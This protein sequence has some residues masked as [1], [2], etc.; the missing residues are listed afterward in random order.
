MCSASSSAALRYFLFLDSLKLKVPPRPRPHAQTHRNELFLSVSFFRPHKQIEL[1]GN[2]MRTF[3]EAVC[4]E[5][6]RRS[7][8]CCT[9]ITLFTPGVHGPLCF[10]T[11]QTETFR[12]DVTQ[13]ENCRVELLEVMMQTDMFTSCLGQSLW[14]P[15]L[16]SFQTETFLVSLDARLPLLSSLQWCNQHTASCLPLRTHAVWL[17]TMMRRVFSCVSLNGYYFLNNAAPPTWME[18]LV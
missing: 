15:T 17:W 16:S 4:S 7:L 10:R 5:S 8:L 14:C 1:T 3:R 11:P 18:T 12:N 6:G 9:L 2:R 13:F